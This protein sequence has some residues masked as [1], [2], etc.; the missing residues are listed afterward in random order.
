[1]T[2][3]TRNNLNIRILQDGSNDDDQLYDGVLDEDG[4]VLLVGSTSGEWVGPNNGNDDFALV[5]LAADGT[6]LW[7]AQVRSRMHNKQR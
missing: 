2:L 4:S 6:V 5:K 1:M 7:R 3:I